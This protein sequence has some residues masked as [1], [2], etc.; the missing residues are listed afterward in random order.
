MKWNEIKSLIAYSQEV[1]SNLRRK[2]DPN[3]ND[4]KHAIWLLQ[5]YIISS[6]TLAFELN[7]R[8]AALSTGQQPRVLEEAVDLISLF[9]ELPEHSRQL[10]AWFNEHVVSRQANSVS[11]ERRK[12]L[13]GLAEETIR[14]SDHIQNTINQ[15]WARFM[16][17]TIRLSRTNLDKTSYSFDYTHSGTPPSLSSDEFSRFFAFKLIYALMLP[18]RLLTPSQEEY[19]ILEQFRQRMIE[20][21]I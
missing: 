17:P 21:T 12:E 15:F 14:Q 6:V 4:R 2:I 7:Q 1:H 9:E 13:Y 20:T 18:A 11:I 16:H 3:S 8:G 10:K 5:G 19:Q